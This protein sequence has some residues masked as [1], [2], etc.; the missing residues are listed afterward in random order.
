M[1]ATDRCGRTDF[2]YTWGNFDVSDPRPTAV[3]YEHIEPERC[4]MARAIAEIEKEIRA[5]DEDEKRDLLRLLIAELD[6]PPDANVEKAWLEESQRRYRELVERRIA[7]IPGRL[8]F[9]QVRDR[10]GR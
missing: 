6:T 4:D 1:P 8:V 3:D 5:L 10:L 9:Q 7:S 2:L